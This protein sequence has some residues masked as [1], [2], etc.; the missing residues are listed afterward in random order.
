MAAC[1]RRCAPRREGRGIEIEKHRAVALR[2]IHFQLER[3]AVQ[4]LPVTEVQ[5]GVGILAR[6]DRAF[7][8]EL[9]AGAEG[10]GRRLVAR[11]AARVLPLPC[12]FAE[13]ISFWGRWAPSRVFFASRAASRMRWIASFRLLASSARFGFH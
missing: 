3:L 7:Q 12:S 8:P 6:L 2:I 13:A 10:E 4:G 5:P 1:L 9:N 11:R